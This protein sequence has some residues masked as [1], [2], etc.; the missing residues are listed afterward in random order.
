MDDKW[1][2]LKN[3]PMWMITGLPH[4]VPPPPLEKLEKLEIFQVA[5]TTPEFCQLE[6]PRKKLEVM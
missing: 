1:P 5:P 2:H 3:T 4:L 6:K